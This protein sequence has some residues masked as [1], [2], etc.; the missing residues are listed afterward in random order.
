MSF[1]RHKYL[2]HRCGELPSTQVTRSAY[3]LLHSVIAYMVPYQLGPNLVLITAG[4]RV[5]KRI[6]VIWNLSITI[7]C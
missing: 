4:I 1:Y 5:E 6:I 2:G 3:V 7:Q